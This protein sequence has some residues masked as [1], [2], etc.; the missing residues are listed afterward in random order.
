MTLPMPV[1][2]NT[3]PIW[4]LAGIDCLDLLRDQFADIRIPHDV[5]RELQIGQDYSEAAQIQQALDE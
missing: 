5:W 3:S 4:N 1:G 2:S